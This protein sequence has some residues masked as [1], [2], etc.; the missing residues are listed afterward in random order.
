MMTD[1]ERD[2]ASNRDIVFNYSK[3]YPA[4]HL[5]KISKELLLGMGNTQH[6]LKFLENKNVVR[7]R[8]LRTYEVYYNVSIV[9]GRQMSILAVLRQET[10]RTILHY[11]V[12]IPGVTQGDLAKYLGLNPPTVKWC[13]KRLTE[14]GLINYQK[15]GRFVKYS[16]EGDDKEI[17]RLIRSFYPALWHRLSVRLINLFLD[18]AATS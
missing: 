12:E 10:S 13:M 18:L 1:P 11:L 17:A 3:N 15:D 16:I 8:K 9:E 14:I 6:H 2:I 4:S 5:R 7:S